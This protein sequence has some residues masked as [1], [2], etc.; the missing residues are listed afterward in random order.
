[1][2]ATRDDYFCIR[3]ADFKTKTIKQDKGH[4]AMMKESTG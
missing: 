4:H 1:M 2:K 3:K